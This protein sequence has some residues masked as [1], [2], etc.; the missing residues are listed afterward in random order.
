[1]CSQ[2]TK[3]CLGQAKSK[4]NKQTWEQISYQLDYLTPVYPVPL[5]FFILPYVDFFTYVTLTC[6]ILNFSY[7][8][9]SRTRPFLSYLAVLVLRAVEPDL[10]FSHH[11]LN[12][13]TLADVIFTV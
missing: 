10:V 1:M 4:V 7:H 8:T 2:Q 6:L 3:M 11:N 13:I 5:I 12:R 9:L